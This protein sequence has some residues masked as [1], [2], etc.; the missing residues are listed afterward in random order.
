MSNRNLTE[1]DI[2]WLALLCYIVG[3]DAWS[4]RTRH[5]TLS[6]SFDR[7]LRSPLRS[8]LTLVSWGALTAHLFDPALRRVLARDITP[9]T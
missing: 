2:A 5:E 6:G 1:G 7:A 9:P 8:I 4:I 3:Y